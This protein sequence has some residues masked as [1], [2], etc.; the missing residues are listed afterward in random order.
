MGMQFLLTKQDAV[1][2][3]QTLVL[4]FHTTKLVP[5]FQRHYSSRELDPWSLLPNV[6][7]GYDQFVKPNIT[8]ISQWM[9]NTLKIKSAIIISIFLPNQSS[10]AEAMCV[11]CKALPPTLSFWTDPPHM[12]P[13][14]CLHMWFQDYF[15]K[16]QSAMWQYCRDG[17]RRI[18]TGQQSKLWF[19]FHNHVREQSPNSHLRCQ[20]GWRIYWRRG[21]GPPLLRDSK[22]EVRRVAG[23]TE[24]PKLREKRES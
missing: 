14:F 12:P 18:W 8:L 7:S 9:K 4:N 23:T 5:T 22:L 21:S 6:F 15:V 16:M 11:K 17:G 13:L 3:E 1:P 2:L 10:H 19:G 20:Q 24:Q